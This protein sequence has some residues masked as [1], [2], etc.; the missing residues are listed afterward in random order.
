VGEIVQYDPLG[1]GSRSATKF[2]VKVT[3]LYSLDNIHETTI[4]EEDVF[5]QPG[6][7]AYEAYF[8]PALVMLHLVDA[9][10]NRHSF[11][12]ITDE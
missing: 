2:D 8:F 9:Y 1:V 6:N 3:V 7:L 5:E 11:D 12:L 10:M 4:P